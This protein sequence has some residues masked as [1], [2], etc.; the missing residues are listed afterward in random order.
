MLVLNEFKRN[1]KNNCNSQR[2]ILNSIYIKKNEN[3]SKVG[4]STIQNE[5]K[6]KKSKKLK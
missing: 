5:E 6:S 4:M 2:T 1:N 3:H